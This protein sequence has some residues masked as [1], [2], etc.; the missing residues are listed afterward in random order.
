MLLSKSIFSIQLRSSINEVKSSFKL[1]CLFHNQISEID[2]ISH[3]SI[4]NASSSVLQVT[5]NESLI[6]CPIEIISKLNE[7]KSNSKVGLE[8]IFHNC[9]VTYSSE[10]AALKIKMRDV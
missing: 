10:F 6:F 1:S 3:V 5:L 7:V 8:L 4:S 9:L 2:N